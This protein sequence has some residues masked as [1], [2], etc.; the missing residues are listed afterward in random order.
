MKYQ[1]LIIILHSFDIEL[2]KKYIFT[3]LSTSYK[4]KFR[5]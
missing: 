3:I 2:A 1:R 4:Y 5:T